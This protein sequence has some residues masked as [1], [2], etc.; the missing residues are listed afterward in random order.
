MGLSVHA[1]VSL[2][3]GRVRRRRRWREGRPRRTAILVSCPPPHGVPLRSA[4]FRNA[5]RVWGNPSD[6]RRGMCD[7][8]Q[9]RG[10]TDV[11]M[12]DAEVDRSA[13]SLE[14]PSSEQQASLS[15]VL[16]P[17]ASTHAASSAPGCEATPAPVTFRSRRASPGRL[18]PVAAYLPLPPPQEGEGWT[19]GTP[20][21]LVLVSLLRWGSGWPCRVRGWFP[22]ACLERVGC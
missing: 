6:V 18:C 10:L 9:V 5:F 22:E 14:A 4:E 21:R 16:C 7:R 3:G 13:A 8:R 1:R 11:L 20:G 2:A 19:A 12:S 15:A 17:S